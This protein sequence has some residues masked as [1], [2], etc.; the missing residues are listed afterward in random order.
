MGE[1]WFHDLNV[2]NAA[3]QA[4]TLHGG[5]SDVTGDKPCPTDRAFSASPRGRMI[6]F[7]AVY[8]LP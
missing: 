2:S 1:T 4:T 5:V 3:T 8:R 7:G 6:Y